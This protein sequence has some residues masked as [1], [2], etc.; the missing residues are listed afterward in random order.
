VLAKTGPA[1]TA[2]RRRENLA[3]LVVVIG[4]LIAAVDATIVFLALPEIQRSLHVGVAGEVWIVNGYLLAITILSTQM[5]RLGDMFGRARMYETGFVIFVAGSFACALAWGPAVLVAFRVVQGVGGSMITANSG[6]VIA[7][8]FEPSR[9]GR[10]YG[11]NS[12]GWG[13]GA[14]LGVVLGGIIVTYISWRWIFWIS[15][16]IGLAAT[17]LARKVL[18]DRPGSRQRRL[19]WRGSATLGLGLFGLLWAMIGL[20]T[21][22][23]SLTLALFALGGVAALVLFWQVEGRVAEPI[24]DRRLFRIPTMTASLLASLLQSL[25]NFAVLY[26]LLLYLQGL[27]HLSPIGA[28]ALLVPGYIVGAVTGPFAGS[29]ADR[30]GAVIPATL[31]LGIQ[32][33]ALLIYAQLGP[34][35]ALP[36]VALVYMLGAFGGGWFYPSNSSAVM[37]R[38]EGDAF[39]TTAGLLRTFS[40]V[41]MV[42][43]FS[44]AVLVASVTISRQR[45]FEIF[46]GLGR[47][48]TAESATYVHAMHAAF[49]ASTSLMV[50]AAVLSASRAGRRGHGS[51]AA[52]RSGAQQP[53]H[54]RS[55]CRLR[56]G[57]S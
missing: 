7:D 10:A 30:H 40:N 57:G 47:L 14:V 23:A 18:V 12:V 35:T 50:L 16:P 1:E 55:S 25:A 54:Q 26:L 2:D 43:S 29:I 17:V 4:V 48:T 51:V 49:Y 53:E 45:A 56:H 3:L 19:D 37:K 11:V 44:V 8:T 52:S 6:A 31:G 39:G 41:G 9:R 24:L 5:G 13:T 42:F 22:R 38:A 27:R 36:V 32:G 34:A 28:S 15:V 33:V 20:A 46:A 21:E